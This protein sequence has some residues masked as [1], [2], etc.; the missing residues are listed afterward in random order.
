MNNEDATIR[1]RLALIGGALTAAYLLLLGIYGY[2]DRHEFATMKASEV[3]NFLSGAFSPL[4][5]LW[6]VLGFL[7][8]G[9]ELRHSARALYLQQEELRNSVEQQQALVAVTR[10]QLE[11]ERLARREAEQESDRLVRPRLVL[12]GGGSSSTG[13]DRK[14]QFRLENLGTPCTDIKIETR[15][16]GDIFERAALKTA[17]SIDFE[18]RYPGG[19]QVEET[20]VAVSFKDARGR[21]GDEVFLLPESK[22][23]NG[24]A[25]F[26]RPILLNETDRAFE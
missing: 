21:K 9:I 14:F 16:R 18:L 11:M 26:A 7:Q 2:L 4:A 17:E 23:A 13:M 15:P 25:V 5:F 1:P 3:A 8:Q 22:R 20:E 12:H 10:E 19:Q 24:L 6:L